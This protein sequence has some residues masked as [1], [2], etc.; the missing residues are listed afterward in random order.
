MMDLFSKE[1]MPHGHC[2]LWDPFILWLNVFSDIVIVVSY[3][4]IP[5]LLTYIVYKTKGRVPFNTIFLFFAIFIL[6]CGTTHLMEIINVWQSQYFIAGIVK[7]ITAMASI[8]TAV[9]LIPILPKII[10]ALR[11]HDA[12]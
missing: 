8:C 3:Y 9:A 5:L 11:G 12:G 7:A 10:Q 2:Y 4:S 1:F 6:A